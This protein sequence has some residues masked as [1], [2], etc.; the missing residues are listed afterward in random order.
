MKK[1]CE[2]YGCERPAKYAL[3][4]TFPGGR[5]RFLHVCKEHEREIGNENLKR[6]GVYVGPPKMAK[7]YVNK[8]FI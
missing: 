6:A 1:Q 8:A 3:F 4:K 7:S 2:V 5:K